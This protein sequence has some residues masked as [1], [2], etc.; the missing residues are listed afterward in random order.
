MLQGRITAAERLASEAER[1]CKEAESRAAAAES[2]RAEAEAACARAEASALES[3]KRA[4]ASVS[5]L[6]VERGSREQAQGQHEQLHKESERRRAAFNH[7]VQVSA[8]VG[9]AG[10]P[11]T[12][13]HPGEGATR[14][15]PT[16]VFDERIH[17][18]QGRL[19]GSFQITC[20]PTDVLV[21][22]LRSIF[23]NCRRL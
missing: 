10:S 17:S 23:L 14:L 21:V 18:F 11:P 19:K 6:E 15:P 16:F 13:V 1:R 9:R 7:A 5:Q 4:E 2:A 22:S 12:L 20:K 3:A 8:L